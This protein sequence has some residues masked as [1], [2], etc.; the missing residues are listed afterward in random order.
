[1]RPKYPATTLLKLAALH[2]A[3]VAVR[4]PLRL[5]S[6]CTWHLESWRSRLQTAINTLSAG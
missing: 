6:G 4:L 5:T 2:V 1:M 3:L